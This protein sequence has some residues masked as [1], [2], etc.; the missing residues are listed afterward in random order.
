MKISIR[1]LAEDVGVS[2]TKLRNAIAQLEAELGHPIG[3]SQGKGKATL[4]D[5]DEQRIIRA[6]F[7]DGDKSQPANVEVKSV[8]V[9]IVQYQPSISEKLSAQNTIPALSLKVRTTAEIVRSVVGAVSADMDVALANR[10]ALDETELR[11]AM[12]RGALNGARLFEA[13]ERAK[14]LT[15]QQL[16]LKK[17]DKQELSD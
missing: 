11:Q 17:I 1:Q 6:K 14:L 4:I 13:E 3:E 9:E 10:N 15:I 7:W 5:S 16:Q 8:N 12:E 2:H